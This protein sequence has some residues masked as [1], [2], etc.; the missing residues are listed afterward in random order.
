MTAVLFYT[1]D[2]VTRKNALQKMQERT[3][4]AMFV[5]L[6]LYLFTIRFISEICEL[7]KLLYTK[8]LDNWEVV[9]A[10]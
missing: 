7:F 4:V 5:M 1:E 10:S 8:Q 6:S 9:G 3:F 2:Y